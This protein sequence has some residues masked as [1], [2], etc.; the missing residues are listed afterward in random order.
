MYVLPWHPPAGL[1]SYFGHQWNASDLDYT[2]T[3]L[4][5]LNPQDFGF[6]QTRGD[7]FVGVD[8]YGRGTWYKPG[9]GCSTAIKAID[10]AHPS[11]SVTQFAPGWTWETQKSGTPWNVWFEYDKEM[12]VGAKQGETIPPN[13][14]GSPYV[15]VCKYF[16]RNPPP[17][18]ATLVFYTSFCP[19]TGL[20]WYVNGVQ[21]LETTDGWTDLQKQTSLGDLLWPQPEM[22]WDV[23]CNDHPDVWPAFA[24]DKSWNGGGCLGINFSTSAA[25]S[26]GR[27]PIQ[28][29]PTTLGQE[30]TVTLVYNATDADD[31]VT[32]GL[33]LSVEPLSAPLTTVISAASTQ[34]QDLSSGWCKLSTTFSVQDLTSKSKRSNDDEVLVSV[35]LDLSYSGLQAGS[36]G[37]VFYLGQMTVAPV[38]PAAL[39]GSTVLSNVLWAD[40][41]IT[42]TGTASTLP[43]GILTWDVTS[44]F[45]PATVNSTVDTKPQWTLQDP[46]QWLPKFLYFNVYA[47]AFGSDGKIGG[48]G[49]ASFMGTTG[50]D[51]RGQRFF[52]DGSMWPDGI[53]GASK[54]RLYVQGVTDQ[55]EVLPW[56]RCAYID[57]SVDS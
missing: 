16:K 49:S 2:A 23:G 36:S 17:N 55:G 42:T 28:S 57:I 48:P 6:I 39:D 30:Y 56:D 7:I 25:K 5:K 4:R 21:V 27:L 19:G 33:G 31:L 51:G 14:D 54:A 13:D 18:P 8:V 45:V 11:L 1:F 29:L 38:L 50:L 47:Q 20:N 3:F 35:G 34:S 9:F 52:V 44:F 24:A 41:S 37:F 26:S 22:R 32:L 53:L 40:F 10:A 46:A 15:P 12:W 43:T